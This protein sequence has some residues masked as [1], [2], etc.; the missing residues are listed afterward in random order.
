V[1]L[2]LK[3]LDLYGKLVTE[4]LSADKTVPDVDIDMTDGFEEVPGAKRLEARSEWEKVVFDPM[5]IDVQA[6]QEYLHIL[7]ITGKKDA[8]NAIQDL[9][10]K[11]QVF[12]ST[13][14]GP[15][16]FSVSNL[17]WVIEGL[18]RSDLLSNEKR[19]V[20]KDFLGNEIILGE[21][22]NSRNS[23][24]RGPSPDTALETPL[25]EFC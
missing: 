25:D 6:L 22:R 18:Q 3:I 21:V 17:R 11:A 23:R 2:T 9:R 7:F 24:Q 15:K 16:Q 1:I 5:N 19:D 12:E 8:A 10:N 14:S 13:L 4:W 20:L